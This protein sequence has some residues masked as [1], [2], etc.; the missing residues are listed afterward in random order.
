MDHLCNACATTI[1][2]ND[3]MVSCQG[4]CKSTFHIKCSKLSPALWAEVKSSSAIFWMCQACRKLMGNVSF[5]D[6]LT[7][8]NNGFQNVLCEQTKMLEELKGEIRKNANMI[9]RITQKIPVTPLSSQPASIARPL[10]RPRILVD[11]DETKFSGT[12]CGDREPEPGMSLP[13]IPIVPRVQKFWLF[14]S[15]FSPHA[16]VEEITRLVQQN[17]NIDGPIDVVNLVRRDADINRLTFVSFKVGIDMRFKEKAM[18]PSSWQKGIYFR[19][20]VTESVNAP[21]VQPFR[22]DNRENE[23]D[24]ERFLT[25]LGLLK[26]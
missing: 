25:P 17:L 8:A 13:V 11:Q 7:N 18:Q 21:G 6:A 3:N 24:P 26:Q 2:T 1:S 19:E 22:S 5:R 4:F 14:L 12:L 23:A 20:F 9:N 15:R 10:K 16:T